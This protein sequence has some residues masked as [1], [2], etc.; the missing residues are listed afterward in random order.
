MK[1]RI[2]DI[3][4][5]GLAVTADAKSDPWFRTLV[6]DGLDGLYRPGE[7]AQ[8]EVFLDLIGETVHMEG[9]MDIDIHPRCDRC[10]EEFL[11]HYH[12][13]IVYTLIP[14]HSGRDDRTEREVELVEDD[15]EFGAYHHKKLDLDEIL[16]EQLVLELSIQTLCR[17]DCR[18]LCPHCG[19][20]RNETQ[21]SCHEVPAQSPFTVL[22]EVQLK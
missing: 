20:N 11:H 5:Q 3:P 7:P 4:D 6:S 9:E 10:M 18:G 15:I 12:V 8:A 1:I 19:I 17:P 16:R 14:A 21:C 2:Q 22:K 13:D